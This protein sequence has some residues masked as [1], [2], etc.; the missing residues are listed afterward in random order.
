MLRFI[1]WRLVSLIPILLGISL[2]S[3]LLLHL[4]PVDP[5]V[6]YLHVSQIPPTDEAVAMVTKELGLDRP[7][8]VQYLEWLKKA[9]TLDFGK[10]YLTGRPVLDD[11]MLYL[12]ATL[13]LAG[14]AFMMTIMVSLPAGIFAALYKDRIFDH[15]CRIVSFA[16]ASMPSFWLG[17]LLMYLF[18]L[19]LRWFPA[20]GRGS[21]AHTVLP[22]FTLSFLFIAVYM[23][24][25]RASILETLGRRFVLYARAR[26]IRERWVIG[27]HVLKNAFPPVITALGMNIGNLLAGS[28][29]VENVFAWPGVGR[30]AVSAILNR[31]IPVVQ[32]YI[33]LMA[34]IFVGCNLAVDIFCAWLDP[35]LRSGGK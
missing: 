2:V 17:F 34:V 21:I 15:L 3:F 18:A 22:T 11:L 20:L 16:G 12:P 10:S 4:D 13:W 19:K 29:I 7:L 35:R 27:R 5:A 32:C 25:I 8:P 33:L 31:D 23:R 9:A 26:G 14:A 24:F 1:H 28:L 30:Y 6:T